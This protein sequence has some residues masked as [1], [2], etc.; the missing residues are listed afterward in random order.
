MRIL[1]SKAQDHVQHLNI[2]NKAKS[3]FAYNLFYNAFDIVQATTP[4]LQDKA[5]ELRYQVFCIENQGYENPSA[6]PDK[7]EK[8]NYDANASQ[9]LL[10]YKPMNIVLGAV[11]IIL[12]N[13]NDLQNSFPLQQLLSNPVLHDKDYTT[14]S[15]EI[16]R[17]CIS[18]E[19]RRQIKDALTRRKRGILLND[20]T[21]ARIALSLAPIGLIRACFDMA[22][23]RNIQNCYGVMEPHHLN[24]LISIGLKHKCLGDDIDYHGSRTPF[25]MNILETMDYA[26]GYRRDIWTVVTNR[27]KS[28]L[29][30]K[31]L[32]GSQI[33][34]TVN[35]H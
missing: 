11:R 7:K 28:H 25:M 33:Q 32:Y 12:P 13:Q 19:R 5:H 3:E 15:C 8:D 22:L 23:Q 14:N 27:G 9:A 17:L 26:Y 2:Y 35:Q 16:S 1:L 34:K 10:I 29:L 31:E 20:P 6:H 30:A 4:E 24:K 18:Y 21:L